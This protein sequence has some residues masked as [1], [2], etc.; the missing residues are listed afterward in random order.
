MSGAPIPA[1]EAQRQLRVTQL[2]QLYTP[3]DEVFERIVA[4]ASE[5]FH[6]PIALLSIVDENRQWFSAKVGLPVSETPR[7]DSFCAYAILANEPLQVLDASKDARFKDNPLVT[8]EPG[9]RFYA[10]MPLTTPEGLGLGSLCV[11][12][13]QPRA[14]LEGQQLAMLCHFA[15]LAM[16]RILSLRRVNFIDQPTGLFNRDRLLS[17]VAQLQGEGQSR[18]LAVVDVIA[19]MHLNDIVRVLG[20]D[21][22]L[23][24]MQCMKHT[25][26]AQLSPGCSLYR[27]SPTRFAFLTPEAPHKELAGLYDRI[28]DAFEAP[29]Q[30]GT[31]PVKTQVGIGVLPLQTDMVNQDWLRLAISSA[32]DA[33]SRSLGWTHYDPRLDA[34]QQRAFILLSGLSEALVSTSQL[35]LV[36]QP[37]ISLDD[38]RCTSV[39][40][41]LRWNHPVLGPV[42]PAEFI[43]LA[44]KT[45]LIRT[46]SL[47]VAEAAIIQAAQWRQQGARFKVAINVS[48]SDLDGPVLVDRIVEL[49]EIHHL[50]G[51]SLEVEFTESAL[52]RN[53]MEV[54]RQ[55]Q[56]LRSVGVEVAIDDFG[57]GYSN[58]AYLRDLPATTVKLD[59]SFIRNLGD[60]EK[61]RRLVI[62]IIHLAKR[63]DMRVVA[64]GIETQDTCDLVAQWGCDEGQGYL[65]AK[66]MLA[67]AMLEWVALNT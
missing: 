15:K 56:R 41:L 60:E 27:V 33:R 39:E 32:D 21:Y 43:P 1:N 58:W 3:S 11:I 44:E 4:M 31:I 38:G 18:V 37:R 9:I 28:I 36:Y 35:R 14:A 6:T 12:D 63:L 26:Q 51:E 23:A 19:P 22:S 5:Y 46:L 49:L 25:L 62:T 29:V 13:T 50:S 8:G 34:D 48:A 61:D 24:L 42:G 54:N 7:H 30:C 47:W 65:I 40:A 45:A 52:M 20:Y 17:D 66:P 67:E 53:P 59:Q 55:L 2:C 64:E 10:G 57:T 16:A